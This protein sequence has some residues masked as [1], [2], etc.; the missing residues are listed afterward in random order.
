MC[1]E[2]MSAL[3]VLKSNSRSPLPGTSELSL[4]CGPR[5]DQVA[6]SYP[7]SLVLNPQSGCSALH[8][9]CSPFSR[10]QVA[11]FWRQTQQSPI[12]KPSMPEVL[13]VRSEVRGSP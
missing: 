8:A 10:V 1:L 3:L 13:P 11:G 6:H 2:A 9:A 5:V 12:Q 7:P 4:T